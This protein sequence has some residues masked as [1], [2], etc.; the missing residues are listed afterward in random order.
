MLKLNIDQDAF[1]K[2]DENLKE[3]YKNDGDSYQLQV[4]IPT[5]PDNSEQIS[6]LEAKVSKLLKEKSNALEK[7]QQ[8][9]LEKSKATGDAESLDKSWQEKY[10]TLQSENEALKGTLAK[11]RTGTKALNLA[12]KL[13]L[14][15]SEEAILPHIEKRL[16]T[17]YGENG[18]V[19]TVV[20]DA[21]GNASALT[22]D[23]LESELR[24]RPSLARLIV[25][26]QASG[27]GHH[28][29]GSGSPAKSMS[30]EQ[31][32]SLS[33]KERQSFFEE[34]GNLSNN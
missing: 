5:P 11:D 32:N 9:A 21:D 22:I 33:H 10:S 25:G 31:F 1:D 29:D 26:S 18:E 17:D 15:G 27:A 4:D 30:R 2:L 34:G 14:K 8:E 28:N 12:T 6:K 23:D 7:A 20:L 19:K 24:E 3:L 16:R 13:A